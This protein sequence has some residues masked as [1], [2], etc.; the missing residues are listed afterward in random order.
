MFAKKTKWLALLGA[1]ILGA[2]APAVAQ[3]SGALLEALVRKGILTDQE[4]EEIRADLGRDAGASTPIMAVPGSKAVSKLSIGARVQVQYAGL[5]TDIDGTAADPASTNHFFLRRIYLV[6][7]AS[8]GPNWSMNI[9][10]D[11]SEQ[12]FDAAMISYKDG[13]YTVDVGLRK[14]PLGYEELTSSGS[15]KAIERS[16]VTRYFVEPN[17]GRRLGASGYRVGVFGEGKVGNFV[18]GAAITNPERVAGSTDNGN[19]GNN[20]Q[21]LWA[22]G[23][24]KGKSENGSYTFGA[25]VGALPD[26]GGKTLGAGNDLTIYSI[27]G[28]ITAGNLQVAAEYLSADVERGA[29]ATKD[30]T[31]TGYWVQGSYKFTSMFEGV[32]RFSSLDTDGRGVNLSDSVRSAPG[33]G[34]H[35]KLSEFFIGGNWYIK[36]NDLKLQAGYV[37]G[38]SEDTVTG[39][40]AGATASGF[41][42]QMQINF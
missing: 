20:Q 2:A 10:Y 27:F 18:Y 24:Y 22:H 16:G 28:D 34:T 36:G 25:A 4:A 40:V 31:P 41:R 8:M 23:A 33:G 29:S 3:D 1:M 35:D 13:D 30:A 9:T 39:G 5:S 14:A 11:P 42:S 32:A 38:D 19:A 12:L 37:Y 21:A 17:N 15:L 6:T 7:K 26:Q